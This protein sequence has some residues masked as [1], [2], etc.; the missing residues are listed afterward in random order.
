MNVI[1]ESV[2]RIEGWSGAEMDLRDMIDKM[3]IEMSVRN[4]MLDLIDTLRVEFKSANDE[5]KRI[6]N[7]KYLVWSLEHS[8]WWA[9]EHAGYIGNVELAGRYDYDDA[10]KICQGANYMLTKRST[11]MI[12]I[13]EAMVP[14]KM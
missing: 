2:I 13:Y 7:Q 11:G 3:P 4:R 6:E 14:V 12:R 5:T 10:I 9:P 8:A 1:P